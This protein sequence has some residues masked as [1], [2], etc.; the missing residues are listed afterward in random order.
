MDKF[1]TYVKDVVFLDPGKWGIVMD[2]VLEEK[3][4]LGE[5]LI[6]QVRYYAF[7]HA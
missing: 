5:D 7:C 3:Q 4:L 2:F 1:K 6:K